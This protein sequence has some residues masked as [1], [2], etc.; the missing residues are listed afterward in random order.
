MEKIY[1]TKQSKFKNSIFS[2]SFAFV[3][4]L[5]DVVTVIVRKNKTKE[6]NHRDER[7]RAFT[8]YER[9]QPTFY[10]QFLMSYTRKRRIPQ[11]EWKKYSV[12]FYCE[13]KP[14]RNQQRLILAP[15]FH[16]FFLDYAEQR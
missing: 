11:L 12:Q 10:L 3:R 2:L 7:I 9:D 8:D 1:I 5:N 15:F 14:N 16:Y 13:L 4:F 6:S